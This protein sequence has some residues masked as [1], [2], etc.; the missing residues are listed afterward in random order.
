MD[1]LSTYTIIDIRGEILLLQTEASSTIPLS[2]RSQ[3]YVAA[4]VIHWDGDRFDND[5]VERV[6]KEFFALDDV[7]NHDF[8]TSEACPTSSK[9]FTD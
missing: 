6:S 3:R 8:L 2:E 1:D 5:D 4:T 9:T 7:W